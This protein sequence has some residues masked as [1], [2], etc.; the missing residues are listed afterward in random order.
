[1]PARPLL[2]SVG[3]GVVARAGT[4]T[5]TSVYLSQLDVK[6][7][8][9][10]DAAAGQNNAK[11][12]GRQRRHLPTAVEQALLRRPR[13]ML[14]SA[15]VSK[16]RC[17]TKTRGLPMHRM[18]PSNLHVSLA[19]AGLLL[20]TA[21]IYAPALGFGFAWDDPLWYGRVI[22]KS[23]GELVSPMTDYHM[24]RPLLV[25]YN[26]LFLNPDNT[27]TAPMLHAAQIGWHLLNTC[28]LYVLCRRLG[29]GGWA[30]V[31]VASLFAWYPFSHQATAWSAPAQPLA[32]TLQLGAWL[33]YVNVRRQ[34][35]RLGLTAGL[36]LLLFLLALVVQENSAALCLLPLLIEWVLR[37][38]Q[39]GKSGSGTPVRRTVP[40]L[41]LAYPLVA[42]GFGALWLLIPRQSGYTALAFEMPVLLYLAQG[43]VFPLL[44]RPAGYAPEH[45]IAPTVI[46]VLFGLFL[47]WLLVT[48]WHT[49]RVRQIMFALAWSLF[50]IIVPATQLRYSYVSVSSRLLYHASPGVALLWACALLP[51]ANRTPFRRVWRAGGAVALGLI[52]V[53]STLLL[54]GFQHVY[55][56]G[57]AHLEELIRSAGA[58]EERLLYV[59]FPDRYE[60]R[61][62]PYPVGRWRM[63]LAPGSVDLGAFVASATGRHPQTSSRRMPWV[64]AEPRQAGPY[65]INMRGEPASPDQ[66]YQ[67][68]HEVDT[69]HLSRYLTDGS[70]ELQWAGRI[71]AAR[72]HGCRIAT[73]GQTL[74]LQEAQVERETDRLS[75]TLSWLSLS[76]AQPHDTVFVHVG[77]PG[78]PPI[79]QVDGDFWL[80]MLPLSTLAQGDAIQE[81]RLILLPGEM[82]LGQCEVSVGV[83]SRLTEERLPATTPQGDPLP[84]DAITIG[85]VP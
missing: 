13:T 85:H 51:P 41:A 43:L 74:C 31:A 16:S 71:T 68:A 84:G 50:G 38:S 19:M 37:R 55:A 47:L 4:V 79:A 63:I 49:G 12:R 77:Q 22:G 69:I 27:F 75:V 30:A 44:G 34:Q 83:Y 23:L 3:R 33:T 42:A 59:N 5:G 67:L 46:V 6:Q 53:Q 39:K 32:S 58:G 9:R 2:Q 76:P 65:R 45:S 1:M 14:Y 11:S 21:W 56:V 26:R 72:G 48:A 25:L 18:A 70:F 80:G 66:L 61:R 54:A 17:N 15:R 81:Q 57:A 20:I 36:S 40:W 24:Y 28:L 52:A 7:L 29:L 35:K 73:F 64:D 62:P 60:P 10:W 82:P 78:Q 8:D